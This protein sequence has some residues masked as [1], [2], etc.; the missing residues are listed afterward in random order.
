MAMTSSMLP[1]EVSVNFVRDKYASGSS[2][3]LQFLSLSTLESIVD[4]WVD[5]WTAE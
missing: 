2:D 5:D 1:E 3:Y 4:L